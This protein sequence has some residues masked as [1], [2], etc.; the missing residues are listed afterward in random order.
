MPDGYKPAY[1]KKLIAFMGR[2]DKIYPAPPF[3]DF[4]GEVGVLKEVLHQWCKEHPEFEEAR[5]YGDEARERKWKQLFMRGDT[6]AKTILEMDYKWGKAA[7]KSG[8]IIVETPA[9]PGDLTKPQPADDKVVTE[10]KT[11]KDCQKK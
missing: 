1:C 6:R 2:D 9:L 5:K 8:D 10:K 4:A 11:Q 7:Q 3:E